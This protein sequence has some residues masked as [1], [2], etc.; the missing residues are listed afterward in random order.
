MHNCKV[1][2][3][4]GRKNATLGEPFPKEVRVELKN[5][6][7][8]EICRSPIIRAGHSLSLS[9]LSLYEETGAQE[10]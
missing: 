4:L 5:L 6:I 9:P 1:R 8:E 2:S 3:V 10:S 7:R